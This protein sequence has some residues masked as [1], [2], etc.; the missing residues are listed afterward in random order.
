M[1]ACEPP[2]LRC[3][4]RCHPNRTARRSTARSARTA[5][6][7]LVLLHGAQRGLLLRLLSL[8]GLHR[9][10]ARRTLRLL[11]LPA[12]ALELLLQRGD[13]Y[14]QLALLEPP[15]ALLLDQCLPRRL[16]LRH[17]ELC[18][19]GAADRRARRRVVPLPRL[20]QRQLGLRGACA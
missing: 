6:T 2:T 18:R 15:A 14:A 7:H 19:L 9:R 13:G 1:T 10:N 5:R 20:L 16:L 8:H 12:Q 17:G 3:T 11:L 4:L